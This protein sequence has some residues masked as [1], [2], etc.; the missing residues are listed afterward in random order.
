MPPERSYWA[1]VSHS[2]SDV[3]WAAWLVRSIE[4]YVIPSK[5]VGIDT[6]AGPAPRRFR[7]IFRDREELAAHPDLR[8]EI[9][10][11]LDQTRYLIVVCSPEAA[12]SSWVNEEVAYF[13]AA[14]SGARIFCV[15]VGGRPSESSH[16]DLT[17]EACFPPALLSPRSAA[18]DEAAESYQPI[19]ADL[20]PRGDGRRLALLKLLS[21]MLGV[22]LDAL[23]NRDARRRQRQLAVVAAASFAGM[24]AMGGLA[25]VA[26][27]ARNEALLQR[28]QAEG[29]IE[30]MLVDL[31]KT[32]EPEGRLDA[33]GAVGQRAM[34][35]YSAQS[36]G[37][38]DAD[39][40]G[41][42]SR[43]LHLVGEVNDQKGDLGAALSVFQAAARST[44]ELLKREPD[45]PQRIFDHAQSVYWVG[46][47][48]WRRGQVDE[49]LRRFFE[50]KNLADR[51]VAIDPHNDAWRAEVG[52]ANS[53]LGTVF[54]ENAR[55]AEAVAAFDKSLATKRELVAHAPGNHDRLADL[56]QSYAW[57]ADAQLMLGNLS[58]A[59]QSRLAE[60]R[61]YLDLL[62]HD[63]ND[64]QI[65]QSLIVNRHSMATIMVEQRRIP[66]AVH[67]LDLAVLD[68][69]KLVRTAPEN[70]QFREQLAPIY[71]ALGQVQLEA[72]QPQAAAAA[73]RQAQALA[74]GLVRKD[75][76]VVDWS[77]LELGGARILALRIRAQQAPSRRAL[78][79]AL[80]S[81]SAESRRLDQLSQA[82]P[83]DVPL[84]RTAAEAAL[85]AGDA[86]WA[87]GGDPAAD[88]A[89][90][91]GIAALARAGGVDPS[92]RYDT[93][94]I[95][96]VQLQ[97]RAKGRAGGWLVRGPGRDLPDY[98]W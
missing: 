77:G 55:T 63:P 76:S 17:L 29:L 80:S 19:A 42:R 25:A 8:T 92:H 35:Y 81:A 2:H 85:L 28:R 59:L 69:L 23:E 9:R 96:L 90:R 13:R 87:S 62:A 68:G 7:P 91:E 56:G 36:T 6:P 45:N 37:R 27:S 1:F 5:L 48:A 93:G 14:H 47:I 50:Y 38:L 79:A 88:L 12:R 89:W 74:E 58:S 95:L 26:L 84:S 66:E 16:D 3:R 32:L 97:A 71:V 21:G 24:V 30:F 34:Q 49:A 31:R 57:C 70:T 78:S 72:G 40:L 54:L 73:A 83:R 18:G 52:Y 39:S 53:N 44:G 41:R 43:V 64:S 86:Q 60:R 94:R 65:T 61:I 11:V 20:R 4:N 15:I 46:Y 51:L 82:H 98:A 33:L 22:G 67:E 10:R 75:P